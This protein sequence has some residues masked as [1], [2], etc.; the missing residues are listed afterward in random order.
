MEAK[1]GQWTYQCVNICVVIYRLLP[2]QTTD[3]FTLQINQEG[4]IRLTM[5]ICKQLSK[6]M[7]EHSE[8]RISILHCSKTIT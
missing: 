4:A 8:E 6:F 5:N 2:S 1:A 3:T 7:K